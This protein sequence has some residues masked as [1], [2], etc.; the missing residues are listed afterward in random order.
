WSTGMPGSKAC[1][2]TSRR[3]SAGMTSLPWRASMRGCGRVSCT[4]Q[5]VTSTAASAATVRRN[6]K[7]RRC[8]SASFLLGVL[9]VVDVFLP[10]LLLQLRIR[11]LLGGLAQAARDD[12]V[13][14]AGGNLARDHAA[15][16]AARG[17]GAAAATGLA[18]AF[19]LAAAAHAF[20]PQ[21][22]G[23]VPRQ[24]PV[25]ILAAVAVEHILTRGRAGIAG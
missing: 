4:T 11:F 21:V 22:A 18:G 23:A 6:V 3:W 1:T 17:A 10:E 2:P 14:V 25:G 16:G 7:A 24:R 13:V 15:A 12:V 9:F 8:M 20:G 5:P 19:A